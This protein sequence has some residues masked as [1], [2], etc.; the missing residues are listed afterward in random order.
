M[1]IISPVMDDDSAKEPSATYGDRSPFQR[2]SR[3]KDAACDRAPMAAEGSVL[4]F[5]QEEHYSLYTF[6]YFAFN[7]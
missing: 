1:R 6:S 3:G 7:E 5:S 2:P 4:F